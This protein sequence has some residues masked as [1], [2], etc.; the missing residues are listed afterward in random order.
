[1]CFWFNIIKSSNELGSIYRHLVQ[2][3]LP[4]MVNITERTK[5]GR[6]IHYSKDEGT[7]GL[8]QSIN[9]AV[10]YD[11]INISRITCDVRAMIQDHRPTILCLSDVCITSYLLIPQ[12]MHKLLF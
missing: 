8:Q 9:I 5:S 4:S 10:Q 2:F 6:I 11:G 7:W 3:D 1:M 12:I